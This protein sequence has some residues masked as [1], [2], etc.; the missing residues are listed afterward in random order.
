MH[1]SPWSE[2]FAP[3]PAAASTLVTLHGHRVHVHTLPSLR[4]T[5]QGRSDPITCEIG[6]DSAKVLELHVPLQEEKVPRRLM[7]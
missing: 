7:T 3:A 5:H 2:A 6:S 4:V 1:E